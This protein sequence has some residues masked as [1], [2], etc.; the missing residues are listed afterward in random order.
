MNAK[1]ELELHRR[2]LQKF[3]CRFD[4]NANC[5]PTKMQINTA[6]KLIDDLVNADFNDGYARECIIF[7]ADF[8]KKFNIKNVGTLRESFKEAHKVLDTI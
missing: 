4:E 2:F 1:E 8:Y 7:F 6:E 3:L 5:L